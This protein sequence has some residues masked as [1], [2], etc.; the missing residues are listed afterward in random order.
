[1]TPAVDAVRLRLVP[2][3]DCHLTEEYVG[4]LN[5]PEVVR[6]SELRHRQQTLEGC[7]AY[8]EAM[9]QAGNIFWAIETMDCIHIG[10]MTAIINKPNSFAD[11][12]IVIGNRAM[13]GQGHGSE[14]WNSACRYLIA[15]GG[16]RKV[17]AGTMASN[18]PMLALMRK[19][20][21]QPDGVWRRHLLL[22]GQ[23]IDVIFAALFRTGS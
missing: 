2:F 7:R 23:E 16:M 3:E 18:K 13:W 1:V 14:A 5:G 17:R 21:M 22:D 20:G 9:E 19:A 4:W 12:S 6:Y 15:E 10:N 8:R 11:L